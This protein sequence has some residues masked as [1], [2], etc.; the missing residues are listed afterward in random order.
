MLLLLLLFKKH[1]KALRIILAI[2][3]LLFLYTVIF[4]TYILKNITIE[5][6]ALG[7]EDDRLFLNMKFRNETA[8]DVVLEDIKLQ[9]NIFDLGEA[10]GKSGNKR[11][12][13]RRMERG[14]VTKVRVFFAIDEE[15]EAEGVEGEIVIIMSK[16]GIKVPFRNKMNLRTEE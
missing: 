3:L 12:G 8:F 14:R 15:Y 9:M 13:K 5:I 1:K 10:M 4:I 2:S 11:L 7:I 16:F 6:A